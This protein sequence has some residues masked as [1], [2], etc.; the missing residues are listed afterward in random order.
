MRERLPGAPN[1]VEPAT[2]SEA[3]QL[4]TAPAPSAPTAPAVSAAPA[5]SAAPAPTAP[6]NS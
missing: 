2:N 5:L 4:A 3:A 6:T 1:G